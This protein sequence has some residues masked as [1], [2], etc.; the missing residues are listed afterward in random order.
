MKTTLSLILCLALVGCGKQ[1]QDDREVLAKL[2]ALKTELTSKK[3]PESVRWA[4]A[5]KREIESAVSQWSMKQ[6]EE[7]KRSE[8]LPADIEEKVRAYEAMQSELTRKRFESMRVGGVIRPIPYDSPITNSDYVALSNKLVEARAPIANVLE[9]RSQ[10]SAKLR[11]QFAVEKLV[12]E[13]AKDRFDLVVD[14]SDIGF[15]RNSVL[16]RKSGEALDI[17]EGVIQLL[18]EKTK[19]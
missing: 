5:N 15:S 12:A 13:Y 1:D 9:R 8:G 7:A 19:H 10:A 3:E 4:F 6:A 18:E 17:T 11:D 2:D 16:Y 14:S